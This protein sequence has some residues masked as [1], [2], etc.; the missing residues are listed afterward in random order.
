[1]APNKKM[2]RKHHHRLGKYL[3]APVDL[4]PHDEKKWL[5]HLKETIDT[6]E[7]FQQSQALCGLRPTVTIKCTCGEKIVHSRHRVE[8]T[9]Q[10]QCLDED[11]REI[12]DVGFAA[13]EIQATPRRVPFACPHCEAQGVVSAGSM[14]AGMEVKCESC[15]AIF[16]AA[17]SF[18]LTPK[19]LTAAN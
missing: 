10:M 2:L 16:I 12:F 5:D 18:V 7:T 8:S 11:C 13:G 17:A 14:R 1:M 19:E 3:H 4:R 15:H 9:A 6:L